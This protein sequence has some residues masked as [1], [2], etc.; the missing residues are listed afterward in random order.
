MASIAEALAG[1]GGTHESA[2]D[3]TAFIR[4]CVVANLIPTPDYVRF[5]AVYGFA[6]SMRPRNPP[7]DGSVFA[8]SGTQIDERLPLVGPQAP[9]SA[10]LRDREVV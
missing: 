7:R 6:P 4:G 9:D 2:S 3:R 8:P 10:S 5:A 1:V